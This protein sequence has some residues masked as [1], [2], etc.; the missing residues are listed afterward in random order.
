MIYFIII[1]YG[2]EMFH[3]I[4]NPA[5]DLEKL[6]HLHNKFSI[7]QWMNYKILYRLFE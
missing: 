5:Y 3:E 1:A 7:E 6:S 2:A 4:L